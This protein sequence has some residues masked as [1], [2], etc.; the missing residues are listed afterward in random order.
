MFPLPI[1]SVLFALMLSAGVALSAPAGAQE[2]APDMHGLLA[3]E[4]GLRLDGRQLD[5]EALL[6]I[7]Q[8]RDFAPLWVSEPTREAALLRALGGAAEHGLDPAAFAVPASPPEKRELLLTD[9]FL[10]YATALARGRVQ[11]HDLET[12]WAFS[13]P[14]FDAVAALDRASAGDVGAILAA[15]APAEPGYRLLQDA[16]ARYRRIAAGGG[17]RPVPDAAKLKRDDRGRAVT[18]LRRRLAAE[19]YL[20]ADALAGGFD[21]KVEAAVRRFQA[22]HGIAADGAVGSDT[23]RALNVPAAARVEQ[24]RANLE[25]WREL[26]R[27]WPKTRIEVNVPGATLTTIEGGEPRL[28][29]RAIVGAEEHPTPVMRAHLS[30]VLF[31]PAWTIPA[32]IVKNEILPKAKRDPKYLERNHYVYR[33]AALQQLPGANNA[34]GRLKFEMPNVYDVY[35]HDTPSRPLFKRVSRS[36]SHGCVRLENPRELAVYLLSGRSGWAE[37]DIDRVI[38]AG[39]TQRVP[40]PHSLPVYLLYWTAFVDAEGAVEFRDD[41]YARDQRL[42]TALATRDADERGDP[43][44][45]PD[46]TASDC[47]HSN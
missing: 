19:G 43:I 44:P 27:N 36:L 38:A 8:A 10:R 20:P 4:S 37:E 41:V 28:V 13:A 21:G 47:C 2:T 30:A 9:A 25:R 3:D 18:A 42:T 32:S 24:I 17:W 46:Q 26:P 11:A 34:L 6:H 12:D 14:A 39:Q 7:Y 40:L 33:G 1:R 35:L 16:L 23:F 22:Q 15:L 31:N 45:A 5:R 29:M